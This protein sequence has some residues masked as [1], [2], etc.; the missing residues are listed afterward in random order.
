VVSFAVFNKLFPVLGSVVSSCRPLL[1]Y[2]CQKYKQNNHTASDDFLALYEI[3]SLSRYS[4]L[5]DLKAAEF[6]M[7]SSLE[8]FLDQLS[9]VEAFLCGITQRHTVIMLM[10]YMTSLTNESKLVTWTFHHNQP[11]QNI[12]P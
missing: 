12:L 6:Y 1:S 11:R 2:I 10:L 7:R 8:P 3:G 9:D 5:A 4:S